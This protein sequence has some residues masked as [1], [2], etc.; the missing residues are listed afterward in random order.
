MALSLPLIG[1]N[2]LNSSKEMSSHKLV[3]P[4]GE[5]LR[6]YH[7]WG[8]LISYYEIKNDLS[9][10][11]WEGVEKLEGKSGVY[12]KEN[13]KRP[14]P[15]KNEIY[16]DLARDSKDVAYGRMDSK[17]VLRGMSDDSSNFLVGM[18]QS[19]PDEIRTDKAVK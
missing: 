10:L 11:V 6:Y 16:F 1:E 2:K 4:E 14:E 8:N 7:V 3:F 19:I 18:V 15:E 17:D 12:L 9:Y 5:V 13:G